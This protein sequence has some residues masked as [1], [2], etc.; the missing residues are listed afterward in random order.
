MRTTLATAGLTSDTVGLISV[1][2]TGTPL[3]DPIEVGAVGQGLTGI[4]KFRRCYYMLQPFGGL[5][6]LE[7]GICPFVA[8]VP[9]NLYASSR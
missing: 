6:L 8:A 3:G 9:G 4:D 1:H 2:G 5:K 7:F